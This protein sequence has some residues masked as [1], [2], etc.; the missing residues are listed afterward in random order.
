MILLKNSL[1]KVSVVVTCLIV[2]RMESIHR[3]WLAD[4]VEPIER[5]VVIHRGHQRKGAQGSHDVV[6]LGQQAEVFGW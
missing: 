5:G 6:A 1:I 2:E 3:E 4:V